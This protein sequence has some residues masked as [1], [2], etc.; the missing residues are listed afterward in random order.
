V[1]G[2]QD[3]WSTVLEAFKEDHIVLSPF[4]HDQFM[5]ICL[6]R[7]REILREAKP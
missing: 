7:F 3:Q 4:L 2:Y 1:A 5:K 6:D